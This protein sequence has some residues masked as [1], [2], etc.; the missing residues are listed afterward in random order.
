MVII[1]NK[2]TKEITNY[3]HSFLKMEYGYQDKVT[4]LVFPIYMEGFEDK[5]V[6]FE[7]EDFVPHKFLYDEV[8]NTFT[9]NPKFTVEV[10]KAS[11]E[12][13]QTLENQLSEVTVLLADV[14]GGAL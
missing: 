10:P 9:L 8:D 12:Y 6:D 2:F 4:G 14:I 13:V 7:I 1:F 3:S 11:H 5:E